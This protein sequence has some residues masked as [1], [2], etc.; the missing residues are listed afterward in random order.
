MSHKT[1][2]QRVFFG[3]VLA[4][5]GVVFLLDN[6]HVFDASRVLSFWPMV[7]MTVGVLKLT[8][9][10]GTKDYAIGGGLLLLGIA[11]TLDHM[12]IIS[13]RWR[14]LWPVVLIGVGIM[15]IFNGQWG[16]RFG[17]GLQSTNT[18]LAD[19]GQLSLTTVMS[20]SQIKIDAQNFQGGEMT[21]LMAGVEL[22][23]RNAIMPVD[24]TLHI[25]V[26]MGGV[27]IKIPLDWTVVYKGTPVMGG[28]EDKTIPT[29]HPA[30]RLTITGTVIMG[31]IEIRN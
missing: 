30:K 26:A 11:L 6:F 5:L 17:R 23:L 19:N 3:T 27:E 13:V 18:G 16:E 28:V 29:P 20:G 1:P 24:A 22:D 15:V 14:D 4:L 31:G 7:F 25:F 9:A 2:Q 21:V 10:Q 8:Q 12:G